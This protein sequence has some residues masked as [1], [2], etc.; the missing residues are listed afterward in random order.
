MLKW[1]ALLNSLGWAVFVAVGLWTSWEKTPHYV[2]A[3]WHE[4]MTLK[5]NS[6]WSLLI[7]IR[8]DELKTKQCRDLHICSVMKDTAGEYRHKV[9]AWHFKDSEYLRSDFWCF[10][11][12][13]LM[14][15]NVLSSKS[16]V[17]LGME[18]KLP[19]KI[20]SGTQQRW[21]DVQVTN[22]IRGLSHRPHAQRGT[23]SLEKSEE[24]QKGRGQK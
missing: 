5:P 7:F 11:Y 22:Q 10:S 3:C 9:Q 20:P 13:D 8:L 2:A 6:I 19:C 17:I 4:S 18:V 15:N 21:L 14:T 16:Y 24:S 12:D 23:G 1:S